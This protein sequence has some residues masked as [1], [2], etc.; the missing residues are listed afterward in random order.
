MNPRERLHFKILHRIKEGVE[1]D[2]DE[3]VTPFESG[4]AACSRD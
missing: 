1:A 4:R 2:I 3:I